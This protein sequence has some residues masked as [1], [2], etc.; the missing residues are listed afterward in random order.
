LDKINKIISNGKGY[1]THLKELN[2]SLSIKEMSYEEI[3][4]LLWREEINTGLIAWLTNEPI[5]SVT[6][7]IK[8]KHLIDYSK[9]NIV[10][11]GICTH[12]NENLFS[13]L[14]A[15]LTRD[16]I[17]NI[18]ENE[19]GLLTY[20]KMKKS[21]NNSFNLYFLNREMFYQLWWKEGITD[22]QLGEELVELNE[23]RIREIRTEWYKVTYPF[24]NNKEKEI[25]K[26]L[27]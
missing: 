2:K 12:L 16:Q 18:T 8:Q 5:K 22:K 23:R 9:L 13:H 3:I 27:N 14:G 11:K 20:L 15:N 7:T 25:D 4:H 1:F 24:V 6:N 10:E 21:K 17:R 26:F 19:M